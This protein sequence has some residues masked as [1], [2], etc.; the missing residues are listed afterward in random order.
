[1]STYADDR[2]AAVSATTGDDLVVR[3]SGEDYPTLLATAEDVQE[4]LKTVEGVISP[5]VEPLVTQPTVSVQV[6]LAAAQR[7][8]SGR[9][10]CG[11]RPA[12]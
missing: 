6:N 1:M 10:T 2:M 12:R 5:Q 8:G 3:V 4:A 9:V 7:S 11:A